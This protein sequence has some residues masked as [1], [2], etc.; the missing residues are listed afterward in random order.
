MI[1]R[2][3]N[4]LTGTLASAAPINVLDCHQD[5]EALSLL[6]G[7]NLL[8]VANELWLL[9]RARLHGMHPRPEDEARGKGG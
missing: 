6:D 5:F 8:E 7:M 3:I 1:Q 9:K 2:R 4:A